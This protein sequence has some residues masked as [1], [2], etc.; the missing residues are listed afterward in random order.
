M[1]ELPK[2][3]SLLSGKNPIKHTPKGIKYRFFHV[4]K[5]F[6]DLKK[7]NGR[8]FCFFFGDYGNKACFENLKYDFIGAKDKKFNAVSNQNMR[9]PFVLVPLIL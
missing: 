6:K 1:T 8:G 5:R 2:I 9:F 7:F 4:K 3:K